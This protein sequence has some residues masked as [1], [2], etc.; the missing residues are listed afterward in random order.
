MDGFGRA[1]SDGCSSLIGGIV[2]IGFMIC[3]IVAIVKAIG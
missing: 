2:M 3:L 1:A